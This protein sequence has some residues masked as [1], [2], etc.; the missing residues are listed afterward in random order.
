[1]ATNVNYTSLFNDITV[2]L[3]RGGSAISDPTVHAQIPRLINA[4]ERKLAQVTKLQGAI[5]VLV[6]A[7]SG[8]TE[9]VSVI[10]KPDRWRASVSLNY[11]SGTDKNNRTPLFPRS[12]EYARFYWPNATLTAAPKFYSDYDLNHWLVVPTPDDDYPLEIIA[13][14]QPALLS[15]E[16]Q[17]NF[18]TEMTPNLILYGSLLEAVP[19]LKDRDDV[20]MWKAYWDQEI[21][22]LDV[23]DAMKEFDR[24]AIRSR[25]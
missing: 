1:M 6:D 13:Y 15:E 4:A 21:A 9:G 22:T 8:L 16:N 3:E 18:W 2:Y 5:E 23:Q 20:P 14:M 12:L 19:F 25:P 24:A 17:N 7:P 11:G 10:T